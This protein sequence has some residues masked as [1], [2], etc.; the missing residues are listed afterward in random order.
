MADT[1]GP[2][3]PFLIVSDVSLSLKHYCDGLGFECRFKS[4]EEDLF[5]ALVGRGQAQ[6]MIKDVGLAPLPNPARHGE[7]PWDVFIFCKDPEVLIKEITDR[8]VVPTPSIATRDDGLHGFEIAD[9]DR[10]VCFFGR[11][12]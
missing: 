3:T 6:I 7:A 11:P 8:G 2:A 9:P 1:L 5:F 4:T 12:V 10:Y